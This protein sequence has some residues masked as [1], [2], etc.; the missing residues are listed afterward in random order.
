MWRDFLHLKI[1]IPLA[2]S[3]VGLAAG[4]FFLS[5]RWSDQATGGPFGLYENLLSEG[6][7]ILISTLLIAPLTA[8]F[9]ENRQERKLQ[10]IRRQFFEDVGKRIDWVINSFLHTPSSFAIHKGTL[11]AVAVGEMLDQIGR[12]MRLEAQT[13]AASP[14]E[15]LSHEYMVVS[16]QLSNTARELSGLA[17]QL[18]SIERLI[19]I[20]TPFLTPEMFSDVAK[21]S[22]QAERGMRSFRQLARYME[23]T[24]SREVRLVARS[25]NVDFTLLITYYDLAISKANFADL[26]RCI[27]R[28]HVE[29]ISTTVQQSFVKQIYSI[30]DRVFY[31]EQAA[32]EEA[33]RA[34]LS[35]GKASEK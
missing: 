25:A 16:R 8:I 6:L 17:G 4:A 20:Y 26:T 19:E 30:L 11:E 29:A 5:P 7:G 27:E 24:A 10:P 31:S 15:N 3:F 2:L 14:T 18:Q 21:I 33:L 34:R 12:L 32:E 23:G 28:S 1:L 9:V 22:T 35:T 13:I